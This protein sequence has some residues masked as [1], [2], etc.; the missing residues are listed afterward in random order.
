MPRVAN[1]TINPTQKRILGKIF[2]LEVYVCN[3]P[4]PTVFVCPILEPQIGYDLIGKLLQYLQ[5]LTP[6]IHH[7]HLGRLVFP[8]FSLEWVGL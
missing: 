1:G 4:M 3:L 5:Q 7:S 6:R 2:Q 8:Y